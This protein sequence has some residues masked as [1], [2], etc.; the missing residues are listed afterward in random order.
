MR[1][2]QC[3]NVLFFGQPHFF[4]KINLKPREKLDKIIPRAAALVALGLHRFDIHNLHSKRY[5]SLSVDRMA[6]MSMNPLSIF[7]EESQFLWDYL[8]TIPE[9]ESPP[10]PEQS[11]QKWESDTSLDDKP[12]RLPQ[13]G[14]IDADEGRLTEDK[15]N[16]MRCSTS[17]REDNLNDSL[18][19]DDDTTST[20]EAEPPITAEVP[21]SFLKYTRPVKE[22]QQTSTPLTKEKED[23]ATINTC[24]FFE[25]TDVQDI[26]TCS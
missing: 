26:L 17:T 25:S 22:K 15:N 11:L 12:P 14:S 3:Q 10:K 21:S 19:S 1:R 23:V 24:D 6:T 4:E 20:A 16:T 7:F 5:I 13:R 8:P 9:D 18:D 2:Q